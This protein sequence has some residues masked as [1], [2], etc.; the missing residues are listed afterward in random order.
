MKMIIA[1]LGKG[2]VGKT[3]I[4]TAFALEKSNSYKVALISMDSIPMTK[5]IL[6]E[7]INSL[8][9]YEY[10]EYDVRSEWKNTYGEEVYNLIT[11]FFDIDRSIIDHIS[12]A[13]GID[14][15]FMLAKL[16]ELKDKYDYIV[17]DTAA[18]SSTIHLLLL[19]KEF[20]EHINNDI[21]FYLSIKETLSK[22][23]RKN[24]NPLEILNKWKKLAED[25]WNLLKFD[26]QYFI[27]KT[28]DDLSYLQGKIIH[29]ELSKM[30]LSVKAHILNR[31]KGKYECDIKIPEFT[32]S[33]R[34]IVEMVRPFLRKII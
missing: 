21:K 31:S 29:D 19:E 10:T 11:S 18:S 16:L 15:E 2:G 27:V 3:T 20:Y 7:K 25:V 5:M 8:D 4:S 28:D 30:G 17:W 9:V 24:V 32:G 1:F 6:D 22:I 12:N 34:E 26:T 14:D 23:R 33:S 13:P